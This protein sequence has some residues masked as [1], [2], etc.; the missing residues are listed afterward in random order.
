MHQ[1]SDPQQLPFSQACENNKGPIGEVLKQCF[2]D[3]K[4][5]LEV[6]SGTGQHALHFAAL[7]PHLTWQ[8]SERQAHMAAL[9]ARHATSSRNNLPP[10]IAL[11]AAMSAWPQGFD[12]VFSANTLHIMPWEQGIKFFENAAHACT[13]GAKLAV[14]GPFNYRGSYTSESNHQFDLMLRQRDATQGLRHFEQVNETASAVGLE[15]LEDYSM[16]ANN[17]LIV[18]Q[19]R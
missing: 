17:R 12:G 18:W 14:Y 13:S 2:A 7:L 9:Q 11:D 16:P 19:L 6:G 1:F 15:L 5:V 4:R 10:P 3:C 8:S